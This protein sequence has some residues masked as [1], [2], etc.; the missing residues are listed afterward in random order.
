MILEGGNSLC[1]PGDSLL[2]TPSAYKYD[3]LEIL[4]LIDGTQII[5]LAFSDKINYLI[6]M[7]E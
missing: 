7:M 2:Y 4:H 3:N 1:E 5:Y 6:Y